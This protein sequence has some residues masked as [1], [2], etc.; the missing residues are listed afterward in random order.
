MKQMTTEQLQQTLTE[1]TIQLIDVRES[2]EY[3]SG[4]IAEAKNVPLSE[5]TER[6]DELDA[7]RPV[8]IICLSGGR[9]MNAA[10]Y[11]DQAGF[12]VTNVSGGMMSYEGTIV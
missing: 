12:D 8:H 6:T 5:L 11:L 7:S 9:S 2:H 10:M 3:E 4:H 1:S